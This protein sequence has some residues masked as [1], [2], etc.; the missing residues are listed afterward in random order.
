MNRRRTRDGYMPSLVRLFECDLHKKL[1]H[2]ERAK[3][4]TIKI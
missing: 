3:R 4:H 2:K 1:I